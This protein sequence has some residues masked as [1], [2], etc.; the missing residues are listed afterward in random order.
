MVTDVDEVAVQIQSRGVSGPDWA[1]VA[2][3]RS[4]AAGGGSLSST[5]EVDPLNV[6]EQP[7][8]IAPNGVVTRNLRISAC[9]AEAIALGQ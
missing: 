5:Q 3:R 6:R 2:Q 8:W 1:A 9:D 4:C 7:L